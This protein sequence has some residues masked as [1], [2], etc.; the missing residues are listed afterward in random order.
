MKHTS[1]PGS[2]PADGG[3]GGEGDDTGGGDGGGHA[4]STQSHEPSAAASHV[5]ALECVA[6]KLSKSSPAAA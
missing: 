4:D 3:D 5:S 2:H 6:Q 1:I